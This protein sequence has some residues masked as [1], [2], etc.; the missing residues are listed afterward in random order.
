VL[1]VFIPIWQVT[2]EVNNIR[3][4]NFSSPLKMISPIL[5]Y[6]RW[7]NPGFSRSARFRK[8]VES[9]DGEKMFY[10]IG[11]GLC[12]EKDITIRGLE[13]RFVTLD[14]MTDVDVHCL[15][16]SIVVSRVS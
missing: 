9:R 5:R 12:D 16:R 3:P 11:L 6:C 7:R 14:T 8:G 2:N 13:V 1:S 10:I 15:G 4:A